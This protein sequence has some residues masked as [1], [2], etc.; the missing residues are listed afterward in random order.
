MIDI[1]SHII[2]GVDDG[3]KDESSTL[4]L[5]RDSYN[6]GVRT[7]IAT[8]HRRKK[9]FETDI[10]IIY[11]N[12]EET[13]ELAKKVADDLVVHL[14]SEI[15]YQ[16]GELKNIEEKKYPTLANT[17]YILIEFNYG[18]SYREL[19]QVLRN[20][21][22]LG[23]TPI[24]AHI[25]RYDCLAEDLGRVEELVDI[26]CLMQVNTSSV[27]KPK[28]FG[29]KRKIY[30]KRA[31]AYLDMNVVAFIASDMHDIERR[32]SYMKQAYDI[33]LEKYGKNRANRLFKTNAKKL[34]NNETV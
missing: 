20:I 29:D 27:L 28:L 2:F 23:L 15:Y 8:P 4:E 11:Q 19:N 26:G 5:L 31:R 33:V 32:P 18:I 7:I 34:L 1:H 9:M 16:E 22:L 10:N 30:K 25:E 12:F 6:Q 3:A 14:G 24:V 13:R 17:D 21:L